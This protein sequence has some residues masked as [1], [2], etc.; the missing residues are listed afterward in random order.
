MRHPYDLCQAEKV[1][2]IQ[3]SIS[4]NIFIISIG[5]L[6]DALQERDANAEDDELNC[7]VKGAADKD[8]SL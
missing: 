4:S 5:V 3:L 6:F 7:G 2:I 8:C 1:S